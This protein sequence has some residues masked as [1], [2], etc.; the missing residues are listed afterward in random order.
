MNKNDVKNVFKQQDLD[1]SQTLEKTESKVN[2]DSIVNVG[3]TLNSSNIDYSTNKKDVYG[4]YSKYNSVKRN[5]G[6]YNSNSTGYDSNSNKSKIGYN[7][8]NDLIST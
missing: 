8:N 7:K 4:K 3:K 6:N 5:H 2:N 1:V